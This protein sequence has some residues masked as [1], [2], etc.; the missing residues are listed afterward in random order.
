M[1]Y[2]NEWVQEALPAAG[3]QRSHL[4][5]GRMALHVHQFQGLPGFHAYINGA[6]IEG[7]HWDTMGDGQAGCEM[8][9]IA[10]L[11]ESLD[12]LQVRA[13]PPLPPPPPE[14]PLGG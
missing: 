13:R 7:V 5:V 3:G 8:L 4:K 6:R 12:I 14:E 1:S 2:E 11:K 10:I 9:A